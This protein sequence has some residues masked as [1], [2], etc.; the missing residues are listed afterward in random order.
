MDSNMI[1]V[2]IQLLASYGPGLVSQIINLGKSDNAPTLEQLT[3]LAAMVKKSE[4]YFDPGA[5]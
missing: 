3:A 2:L 5:R 1:V 4:S